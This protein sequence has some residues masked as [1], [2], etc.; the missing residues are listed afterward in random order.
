MAVAPFKSGERFVPSYYRPL[1]PGPYIGEGADA[2]DVAQAWGLPFELAMAVGYLLRAGRKP[3]E[4]EAKDL[5]K[6]MEVIQR[7][8]MVLLGDD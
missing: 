6:A 5:T 1:R 2:I 4:S 8:L 3:G 7:R